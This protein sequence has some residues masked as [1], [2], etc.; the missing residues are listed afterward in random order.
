MK[1]MLADQIASINQSNK[2]MSEAET[3]TQLD[4]YSKQLEALQNAKP[5]KYS[6]EQY[7]QLKTYYCNKI[8]QLRQYS[9]LFIANLAQQAKALKCNV[10]F[11]EV[12][13]SWE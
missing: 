6:L 7:K 2:V 13:P 5:G 8:E 3:F 1:Q 9:T 10:E 12:N 4:Q 11:T